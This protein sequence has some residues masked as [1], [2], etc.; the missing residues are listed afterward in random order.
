[1][2]KR[3][4]GIFGKAALFVMLAFAVTSCKLEYD[5][6]NARIFGFGTLCELDKDN[7]EYYITLDHEKEKLY[8]NDY[9]VQKDF[10]K[11]GKR[12]AVTFSPLDEKIAGYDYNGSVLFLD[13]VETKP[14]KTIDQAAADTIG[15]SGMSVINFYLFEKYLHF[16]FEV[17]DKDFLNKHDFNLVQIE[18]KEEVNSE[19]YVCLEFRHRNYQE[20]GSNITKKY[21]SFDVEELLQKYADKKGIQ[22]KVRSIDGDDLYCKLDFEKEGAE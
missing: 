6:P 11:D 8:L 21:V 7:G 13:T 18:G 15:N 5:G 1:M 2:K 14:F 9:T 20:G 4:F 17:R 19:G 12:V 16:Y 22:V 3:L 10:R